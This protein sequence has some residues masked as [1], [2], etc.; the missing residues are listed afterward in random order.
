[1]VRPNQIINSNIDGG[2]LTFIMFAQSEKQVKRRVV[3]IN[4]PMRISSIVFGD[5]T[6]DDYVTETKLISEGNVNRY[7]VTVELP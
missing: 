4:F 6:A 3:L 5:K 1:M 7:A 2:E